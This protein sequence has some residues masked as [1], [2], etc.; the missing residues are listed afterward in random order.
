MAKGYD[1]LIVFADFASAALAKC[2]VLEKKVTFV[3]RLATYRYYNMNPVGGI[4]LAES[5]G[6]QS[7]G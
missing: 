3:C 4:A 1:F 7:N 5:D 2:A 6:L